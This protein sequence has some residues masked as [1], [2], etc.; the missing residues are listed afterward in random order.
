MRRKRC[1]D[2]TDLEK[3]EKGRDIYGVKAVSSRVVGPR[4]AGSR[5][6]WGELCCWIL[7]SSGLLPNKPK[8]IRRLKGRGCLVSGC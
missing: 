8:R 5:F 3:A 1:R 4:V 2:S 6:G 7:F